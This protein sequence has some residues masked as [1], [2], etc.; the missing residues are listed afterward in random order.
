MRRDVCFDSALQLAAAP[1]RVPTSLAR[2]VHQAIP[3][4]LEAMSGD[5]AMERIGGGAA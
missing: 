3:G 2:R 4:E 5:Q 1:V